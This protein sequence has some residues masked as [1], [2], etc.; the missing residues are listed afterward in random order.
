MDV[1]IIMGSESDWT[2]MRRAAETL[3]ELG[4]EHEVRIVSAHRT[5]QRLYDYAGSAVGRVAGRDGSESSAGSLVGCEPSPARHRDALAATAWAAPAGP[6][7]RGHLHRRRR[8][9][10]LEADMTGLAP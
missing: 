3:T 10:A 5:P 9:S 8:R 7:P 6:G 1:G 2:T 4:V